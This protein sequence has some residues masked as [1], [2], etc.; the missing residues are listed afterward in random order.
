VAET[1]E[2]SSGA[3]PVPERYESA[4]VEKKR[5]E[6]EEREKLLHRQT[7]EYAEGDT[8]PPYDADI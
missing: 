7:S 4:E 6:R 3:A 8:P 1:G 5:L 2:S